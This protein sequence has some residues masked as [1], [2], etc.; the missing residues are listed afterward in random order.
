MSGGGERVLALLP[1]LLLLLGAVGGLLLGLWTPQHRQWRVR[2][3]VTA[4]C[5]A[6]V[7]AAAVALPEP[8]ERVFEATWV[9]DTTTGVVRIVV[10]LGVAVLVWLASPSLAGHP[11]ET[12]AYVLMLLGGLGSIAL[13]A[14]GDLLLLVAGYLLA[15]VP[16]YALAGFAKDSAGVEATMKYY[17]MGAF[18]GVL[19]LVGVAALVLATGTTGYLDLA[20]L[21]PDA[22]PALLAV[23]ILGVLA[24]VAFKA[25]AV[26]VHFWVPDVTAGTTPPMAAYLTTIPKIGAVAAAFRLLAEPFADVPLDVPLLV[27]VIAAVSM[28]LG[29]LAAFNQTEV[30]RLLAYSTVSQVGY[31]FMAVAVAAR[32]DLAVPAL[33]IYL[34]GY[35]VTNIGAFA[36]VAATPA[37]RTITDWATA[38]GRHRWIVVSLVVCLL[39]LVGTPPTAVFVGKLAVF[40]AAWDGALAWLVVVAAVNTVASLFYYL[41]WVAP[42]FAG[43]P[44]APSMREWAGSGPRTAAGTA[45]RTRRGVPTGLLHGA[46]VMSLLLGLGAGWWLAFALST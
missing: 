19:M 6:S 20:A 29:N 36:A 21:L 5:L 2:L 16:L 10:A 39:G 11:R 4:A 41:R 18:V 42:A 40:T 44:A 15:S 14:S 22:S 43:V 31:L 7:I 3:L 26:P 9:V 32:T 30:L 34:A 38:V 17:L 28:T 8:A 27:A 35:A 33:A 1:E 45:Q 13:A 46:A 23:G 24:G 12:E 37:A 25:G